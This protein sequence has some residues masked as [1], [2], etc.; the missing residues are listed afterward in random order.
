MM[1]KKIETILSSIGIK[2]KDSHGSVVDP[3]Y[4]STNYK[5]KELGDHPEFDYS[6][7]GNPTRRLL[8][9]AL[10]ESLGGFESLICHPSSMTHAPLTPEEKI[11]AGIQENLLRISVGLENKEDLLNDL[12][13][14]LR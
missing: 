14:A 11:E 9:D 4:L 5:F 10:A 1:K 8:E 2:K 12:F 7:S 13:S 6:R 3:L